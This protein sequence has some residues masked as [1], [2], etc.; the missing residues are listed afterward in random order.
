MATIYENVLILKPEMVYIAESARIDS[1]VKIEGG[2]GVT[3]GEFCHVSSFCH[4]NGGGGLVRIGAHSGLASGVKII[5]G[6]SDISLLHVC[7]TEPAHLINTIRSETIIGEYVVI[8]S[9]AVICPGVT[10]GD[11]AIIAAG[12]VVTK[13]VPAWEIHAGVPAKKIGERKV[14]K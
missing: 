13:D 9:N 11:G 8:F 3:I 4:L 7:P 2:N 14:T 1:F 12:A 10:I 5:G 6:M